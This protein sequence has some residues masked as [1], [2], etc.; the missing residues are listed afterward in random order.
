MMSTS[1]RATSGFRRLLRAARAAFKDDSKAIK[2]AKIQLKQEFLRNK[3]ISNPNALN[4]LF[5]GVDEAEELLSFQIVQG[6]KN[7]RGNYGWFLSFYS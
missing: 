5:K 4:E 1:T 2:L 3:D 7:V 6:K